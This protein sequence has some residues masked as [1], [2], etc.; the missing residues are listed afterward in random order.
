VNTGTLVVAVT[1]TRSARGWTVAM[2]H[3]IRDRE[4]G[5]WFT[6]PAVVIHRPRIVGDVEAYATR[7]ARIR[8]R[9]H[10]GAP[11]VYEQIG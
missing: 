5:L 10:S 9:V 2:G 8:L 1:V 6:S 7:I 4:D 3:A 11:V